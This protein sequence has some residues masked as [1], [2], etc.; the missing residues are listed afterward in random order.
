MRLYLYH[1]FWS[2]GGIL[3]GID[4][5][6]ALF[7][8]YLGE[9]VEHRFKWWKIR[10]PASIKIGFAIIVL[11]VA[12]A[13]AYQDLQKD[14]EQLGKDN[15][16]LHASINIMQAK[17]DAQKE[18]IERLKKQPVAEKAQPLISAEPE[19]SG[20]IEYVSLIS[21]RAGFKYTD[22]YIEVTIMNDGTPSIARDF[23]LSLKTRLSQSRNE[24]QP[25][26]LPESFDVVTPDGKV[27]STFHANDALDLK[28][29]RPIN[30]HK[31]VTGWLR[32]SLGD[33]SQEV[34]KEAT[35]SWMVTFLDSDGK[36]VRAEGNTVGESPLNRL[37][38]PDASH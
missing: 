5:I 4:A 29:S 32:Y 11:F 20:R 9:T 16:G 25:V 22:A 19:L 38:P 37:P 23:R 13:M 26:A 1:A 7:E 31:P 6:V 36:L 34:L 8:R 18:E 35:T 33:I 15:D 21:D 14:L 24:M 10:V 3:L 12:Q 28:T 2:W 30:R 27:F 17:I